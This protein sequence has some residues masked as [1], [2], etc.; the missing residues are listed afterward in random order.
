MKIENKIIV[1]V[2]VLIALLIGWNHEPWVDEAQSWIIA[3]D[4]SVKEIVWDISRYEG[5]F[6]L[7]F[8]T[9]KLFIVFGF[10]YKFLYVIST[11]ISTIG[12]IV[13]L[14][15]VEAPRYVKILLPFTYYVLFQYTIVAR[16][17]CYLF[18]AFS[19][20]A[21]TYK[22]RFEKP[23]KYIMSLVFF[24]LI[25]MHGMVISCV[26][27]VIFFIEILYKKEL[28]KYLISFIVLAIITIIEIIILFPRN[29]LYMNVSAFYSIKTIIYSICNIFIGNGTIFH[30]IYNI[31]TIILMISLFIN[32]LLINNKS[33][34]IVATCVFL[35]MSI[36]RFCD[37]H[38]GILY[39]LIVFGTI[40]N[41]EEIKNKNKNINK[42]FITI[43]LLYCI[44]SIQVGINDYLYPYSGAKD[45]ALYIKEMN[46]ENEEIYS[47]GYKSVALE[48]YFEDNIYTNRE[49]TIYK[50]NINNT[51]FYN[52]CNFENID[53]NQFKKVPKYIILEHDKNDYKLKKITQLIDQT[54]KY[55]VEYKTTGKVFFKNSYSENEGYILYKLK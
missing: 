13:F 35:F 29:D 26:L 7:W 27:G 46:Y 16:S 51:D 48:P 10:E 1:I 49:E 54:E 9:L 11:I 53:K 28:K 50:W 21:I 55:E 25:S 33:V 17:Y 42:I 31:I 6:P 12:L 14:K 45:M 22:S 8:L 18:L 30:K 20:Y 19:L 47:F 32:N 36:I 2:F 38:S 4:A 24:S 37:H 34:P 41:Y 23:L 52:Y 3:R 39:Y 15:K 5:T 43:M 40:I 44:Y